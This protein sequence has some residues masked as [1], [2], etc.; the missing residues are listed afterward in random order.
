MKISDADIVTP[1]LVVDRGRLAANIQ[2]LR[3][4]YEGHAVVLRPHLKTVKAIEPAR[5]AMPAAHGP[6]AVST[7]REAEEFG[8]L[9]ISDLLYAVG[10]APQKLER[11]VAL[12]REGIDLKIITDNV[13]AAEAIAA[14]SKAH[15]VRIP[16]LIELDVDGHRSGVAFGET[17]NLLAVG[18][19][20]HTA[21]CLEGVMTHAGESYALSDS[22][23]L[24]NAAEQERQRTASMAETLREAG[25]ECPTVSIGSTPTAF[26]A[27]DTAGI[28]EIRAGVYLFFDL[29]Q[30]GIGVCSIDDIA[31]SV[32]TTVIGHQREKGWTIIDAGWMA[33]SPDRSTEGQ[34]VDQYLGLVCDIEGRPIDDLVVM[35][36]NQ[37]HGIVAQRPGSNA[38]SPELP[39]GTRL[40]ILPNHAC[41]T[42]A[43]H[44]RY[45]VIG[46]G[47]EISETWERFGGW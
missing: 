1:S 35:R 9:G 16:T 27:T 5:M 17:E 34:A 23:A 14:A 38:A 7:L 11:V 8:R 28:S 22:A 39:V 6:A 24:A 36:G 20:L 46:D 4:R 2:R 32:L 13:A 3:Q 10:I 41:A 21:N 26:S 15:G 37:E 45:Q 30:A 12:H 19:I 33:L 47:L 18:R 44:E 29:C 31:L 40:R 42:A 25:M 43:Q